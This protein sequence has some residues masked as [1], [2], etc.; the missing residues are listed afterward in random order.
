MIVA[1]AQIGLGLSIE[2]LW[3]VVGGDVEWLSGQK[4]AVAEKIEACASMHLPHDPLGAGV[5]A[6]GAAVVVGLGDGTVHSG[7]VDLEAVGEAA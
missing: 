1:A 2:R 7:P 5:D 4:D 6:F 3:P